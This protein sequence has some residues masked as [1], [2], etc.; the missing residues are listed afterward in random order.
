VKKRKLLKA[1]KNRW[2]ACRPYLRSSDASLKAAIGQGNGSDIYYFYYEYVL[3]DM[4]FFS[5]YAEFQEGCR[6]SSRRFEENSK[7]GRHDKINKQKLQS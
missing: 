1:G 5:D 2:P 7:V 3:N 4:F 6:V